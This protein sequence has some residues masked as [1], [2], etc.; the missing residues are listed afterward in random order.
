VAAR[1][2]YGTLTRRKRKKGPDVWQFR[3]VENAKLRSV[4]IGT[5]ERYPTESDA[6]RAIDHLRIRIN[7]QNPQQEFHSTTVGALV[8]RFME[9]YATKRCRENTRKNYL[10]LFKN[11][12]RP[13]WGSEFVQ[14][15]KTIAVEDWL[16]TYP[17]SRQVKSHVRNL[18]HTLYQAAIRW[19]M[20]QRNPIDLVRQSS[21]RLKKPRALTPANF[22][23]LLDQLAEPHRTMVLTAACLGLRV[24]ELIA[25][26]WGDLDFEGL[27]I[28]I[29]RSFVRGEINETKNEASEST[30]PLDLDLAEVLLAHKAN[31]VYRSNSDYVFAG[32]SGKPRWPE[33]MLADYLKPAAVRAG[34]GRIGWHTF[35]HTYSTLLHSLGTTPAVQKELLRHANVQTTLNVYTQAVSAEKREAASRVIHALYQT[36][37]SG[38]PDPRAKC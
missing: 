38:K 32:E 3:W 30:L 21:R 33:T 17:H 5:V 16:E 11:H 14:N 18:M 22:T 23:A 9:E 35:R 31:A 25:L 12:I 2:Q 4:L 19:E 6:E 7:A 24:S 34:I 36:V 15:V 13:T 29:A 26:Q 27:T 10:S 8:D 20:V 28:K 37:L 1:Y